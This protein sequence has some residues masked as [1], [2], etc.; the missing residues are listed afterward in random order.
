MHSISFKNGLLSLILPM[1]WL[2]FLQL[3]VVLP[4]LAQSTTDA[5]NIRITKRTQAAQVDPDVDKGYRALLAGEYSQA[6][7]F[8]LLALRRD[9][10]SRDAIIGMAHALHALG[11]TTTAVSA[12]R[13]LVDLYP[14]DAEGIAALS[15]LGASGGANTTD[16]ESRLKYQAERSSRPAPLLY[17][18]GVQYADQNRWGEAKLMFERAVS[19]NPSDPDYHYN[20]ALTLDRMGE[21]QRAL[22]AYVEALNLSAQRAASFSR[23]EARA[24][25]RVLSVPAAVNLGSTSATSTRSGMTSPSPGSSRIA[26]P[27]QFAP[28]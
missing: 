19:Q 6:K 28:R 4:A 23:D 9:N 2:M 20:L 15:L 7:E 21:S 11:D 12:L 14:R 10:G 26:A 27:S 1:F 8:Y 3:G 13:R 22:R 25:A 5:S 24:R 18:L 17:A 16:V